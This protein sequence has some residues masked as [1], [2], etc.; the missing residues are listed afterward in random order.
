MAGFIGIVIIVCFMNNKSIR[1]LEKRDMGID[2][3]WRRC[4]NQCRLKRLAVRLRH[5]VG[6]GERKE[7]R[8][9]LF[10]WYIPM[11]SSW[12]NAFN[13]AADGITAPFFSL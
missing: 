6:F 5:A 9:M 4:Y 10:T 11:L 13:A 2:K 12:K 3:G 1:A 8:V 7:G